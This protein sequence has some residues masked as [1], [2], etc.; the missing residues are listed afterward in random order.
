MTDQKLYRLS[1]N[2]TLFLKIFLPNFWI[3][4]FGLF[5]LMIFISG[6]EALPFLSQTIVKWS[7]LFFFLL[8]LGLFYVTIMSLKRVDVDAQ[9][10]YISNYFKTYRYKLTDIEKTSEIN[11]GLAN[12]IR[13]HLKEPGKM[14][15]RPFFILNKAMFSHYMDIHPDNHQYFTLSSM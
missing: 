12:I 13:I 5:T 14:G 4:F 8:F 7:I 2:M 10:I 11:F 1:S 3:V 9:H 6:N 15:K